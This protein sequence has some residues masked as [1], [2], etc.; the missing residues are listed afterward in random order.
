MFEKSKNYVFRKI[1]SE[2]NSS[3]Y[4]SH[5]LPDTHIFQGRWVDMRRQS[6]LDFH[7]LLRKNQLGHNHSKLRW[8]YNV[9]LLDNFLGEHKYHRRSLH[10]LLHRSN[11]HYSLQ[12]SLQQQN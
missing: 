1:L 11:Q 2:R 7:N 8:H 3:L 6:C 9:L 4:L 12:Y 10:N 5:I